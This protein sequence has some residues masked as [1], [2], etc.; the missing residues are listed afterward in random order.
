[1]LRILA[2]ALLLSGQYVPQAFNAGSTAVTFTHIQGGS[3]FSGAAPP[4]S[5]TSCHP[6]LGS[7][8]TAGNIVWVGLITVLPSASTLPGSITFKDATP[9]TY[10]VTGTSPT[11]YNPTGSFWFHI[12]LSYFIVSGTPSKTINITWTGNFRA[13]CWADEFHKSTGAI[14]YVSDAAN[15]LTLCSGTSAATPSIN[16]G[17]SASLLYSVAFDFDTGLTAPTSGASLG[18]WVGAVGGVE[19]AQNGGAAE[20]DL[21]ASGA[22]AVNYTCG[23]GGDHYGAMVGAAH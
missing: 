7:T 5:A 19:L 20:Y 3:D 15:T 6:S 13:E 17:A 12:Y 4:E 11:A 2:I 18:S 21:A 14:T 16:P 23:A 9:N 22:T 8:P 10:T 1:M